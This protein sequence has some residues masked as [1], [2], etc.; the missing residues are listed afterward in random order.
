MPSSSQCQ[1]TIFIEDDPSS[2]FWM[3]KSWPRP[4]ILR[5][6]SSLTKDVKGDVLHTVSGTM[7]MPVP[8]LCK[9]WEHR[10]LTRP[11]LTTGRW[12]RRHEDKCSRPHNISCVNYVVILQVL[13]SPDHEVT[14][15]LPGASLVCP[16]RPSSV[17]IQCCSFGP[18]V[19][20]PD[21]KK[22]NKI[23]VSI[24]ALLICWSVSVK[25]YS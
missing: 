12:P 23:A 25:T 3:W 16:F 1:L 18:Q 17:N 7:A 2:Y 22:L 4:H 13:C 8:A 6:C 19:Y 14:W 21:M 5:R 11:W 15:L 9:Q 20:Q 24:P 10:R